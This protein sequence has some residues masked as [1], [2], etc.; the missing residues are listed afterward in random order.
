M[1]KWVF[2]YRIQS[3][4]H[5][6]IWIQSRVNVPLRLQ[7]IKAGTDLSFTYSVSWVPTTKS[8]EN[9]FDRYLDYE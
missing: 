7:P 4:D 8:F 1:S 6:R 9:R 5:F 3:R 2:C